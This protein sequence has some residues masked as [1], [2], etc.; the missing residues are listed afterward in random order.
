MLGGSDI[1][2]M[3]AGL[4]HHHSYHSTHHTSTSSSSTNSS[5]VS[6]EA[7]KQQEKQFIAKFSEQPIVL[8]P[9][10]IQQDPRNKELGGSSKGLS[11]RDF[12]LVRTLGTGAFHSL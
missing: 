4:L 5:S 12:E 6:S 8:P 11:V 10:K 3:A 2:K 7:I 9:D 1:K